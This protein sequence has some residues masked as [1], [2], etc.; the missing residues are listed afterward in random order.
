MRQERV[1]EGLLAQLAQSGKRHF[2]ALC[3]VVW[4]LAQRLDSLV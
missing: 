1:S 3:Q 4:L 2:M